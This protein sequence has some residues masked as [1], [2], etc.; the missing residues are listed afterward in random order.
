MSQ[1]PDGEVGQCYEQ[2]LDDEGAA[3]RGL[4]ERRR[5]KRN[6]EDPC[7]GEESS[8]NPA[9]CRIGRSCRCPL[10][11]DNDGDAEVGLQRMMRRKGFVRRLD[12]S[13][14]STKERIESVEG[15]YVDYSREEGWRLDQGRRMERRRAE[16]GNQEC[17][18]HRVEGV[19]LNWTGRRRRLQVVARTDEGLGAEITCDR[20]EADTDRERTS[21]LADDE[22]EQNNPNYWY[23]DEPAALSL[24]V[25][26]GEGEKGKR[27]KERR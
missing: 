5:E 8:R 19:C 4:D 6:I 11:R 12:E 26:K 25:R 16:E 23:V 20:G 2:G 9:D 14:L 27:K 3:R 22:V 13:I 7:Q 1:E 10:E 21:L 17:R 15:Q 24:A 18:Q